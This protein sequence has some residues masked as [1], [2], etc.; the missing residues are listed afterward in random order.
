MKK[1]SILENSK[2]MIP[3]NELKKRFMMMDSR[4]NTEAKIEKLNHF[5]R[6]LANPG[7]EWEQ[8]REVTVSSLRG[9][10]RRE[11]QLK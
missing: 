9:V 6:Q 3:I 10:I 5:C 4:A 7:Y 8:I 2:S 1:R 11:Q